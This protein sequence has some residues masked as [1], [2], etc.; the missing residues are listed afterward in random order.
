[1]AHIASITAR[2]ILDS[3]GIPTLEGKLITKDGLVVHAQIPSG[4]SLGKHEG[5]ELRDKE[6]VEVLRLH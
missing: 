5:I 2:E 1:M 4:E 6:L 3:R